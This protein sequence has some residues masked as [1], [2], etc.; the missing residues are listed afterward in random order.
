[1]VSALVCPDKF[2]GTLDAAAAA[3]AAM[4]RGAAARRVRRGRRAAARRRR[5]GHA[6]RAARRARRFASHGDR[7]PGRSATRST[8]S[9]RCCPAASR[10]SRWRARAGS[11]SCAR[12][13]DPLRAST[14]RHRRAD[15]RGDRAPARAASIVGVGGSA[16]TDGGL[17]AVEALGWSLGAVAGDGRVRRRP[18]RSSTPPRVYGPQKGAT[19][20]AGRAAHPPAR[21][22]RRR[23]TEQRTGVDVA[24]ARRR[25][26]GR[27]ARRRARRD[28][29]ASSSPGFDVVAEAAGLEDALDGADLVVT[30]EGK[31]DATS[32]EGK[33]VGGVL[34]W[35]ADAGVPHVAVIAGQ[36]TDDARDERRA[37]RRRAGARAHR[38]RVA[39]RRGV[40]P[41]RAARR[42]GRGRSRRA[43]LRDRAAC[44]PRV[45]TVELGEW[46][47][48]R[49]RGRTSRGR[50]GR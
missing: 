42:G 37:A 36:V 47:T 3:A 46:V 11:R 41:R 44:A 49:A 15:R 16:T 45:A 40:R 20:G 29:R 39:G 19:D 12:R 35:A 32:F 8:R 48:R 34:E 26:R 25:R 10:W 7:S 6:R 14:P 23:S 24:D 30:G 13:N 4:A 2:R 18:P 33:V 9:G 43:V 5:R 27:R 1:M 28:R 38:P 17:A 31:L 22:A 50:R 21:A